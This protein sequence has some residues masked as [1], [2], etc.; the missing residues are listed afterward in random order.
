MVEKGYSSGWYI[1][2]PQMSNYSKILEEWKWNRKTAKLTE[3]LYQRSG[4]TT[5]CLPVC[6]MSGAVNRVSKS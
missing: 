1:K 2:A 3:F 6:G 4:R 5:V